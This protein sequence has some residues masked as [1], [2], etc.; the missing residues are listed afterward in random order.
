MPRL[1]G[2]GIMTEDGLNEIADVIRGEHA[3]DVGRW[4]ADVPSNSVLGIILSNYFQAQINVLK[5]IRKY[6]DSGAIPDKIVSIKTIGEALE[7]VDGQ[8]RA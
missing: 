8:N 4:Q 6:L 7:E 2:E 3:Q 1:Q 5:D